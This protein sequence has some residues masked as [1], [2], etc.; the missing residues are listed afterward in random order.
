MGKCQL[1]LPGFV[2]EIKCHIPD[3]IIIHDNL[4][5]LAYLTL[6]IGYDMSCLI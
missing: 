4:L 1:D 2:Y 6:G 5:S 3:P